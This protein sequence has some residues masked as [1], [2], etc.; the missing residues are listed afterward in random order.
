HYN[1]QTYMYTSG[2][3]RSTYTYTWNHYSFKCCHYASK[4]AINIII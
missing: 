2:S 4:F 3:L 1:G